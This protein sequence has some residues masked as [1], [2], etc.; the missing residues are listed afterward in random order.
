MRDDVGTRRRGDGETGR[1]G[2]REVSPSP[3]VSASGVLTYIGLGSNLGDRK[4]NV[5]AAAERLSR[6]PGLRVL[7][8]SGLFETEPVGVQDQPWFVNG[9]LEVE[10]ELSPRDLLAALKRIEL[11]LGRRPTRHWGERV[12]DLDLLLYDDVTLAEADLVVPHAELWRRLFVLVP[13]A[14]LL[15]G[16]RAPDDRSIQELIAELRHSQTVRAR[17]ALA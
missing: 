6:E 15:P 9:V 3:R 1:S 17:A 12:I 11:E 13:L 8:R 2:G 7:R 10:A 16:L 5:N 4:A 14:E